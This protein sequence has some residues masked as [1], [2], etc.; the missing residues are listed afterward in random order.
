[1]FLGLG[2]YRTAYDRTAS[3]GRQAGLIEGARVWTLPNPSARARGYSLQDIACGLDEVRRA[4]EM[5]MR[6]LHPGRRS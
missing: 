2:A 5:P 6:A 1:V 4:L 3:V